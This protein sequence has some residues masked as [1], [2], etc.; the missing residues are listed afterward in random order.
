MDVVLL[1]KCV[2]SIHLYQEENDLPLCFCGVSKNQCFESS[3]SYWI[4]I[5]IHRLGI[6]G[7]SWALFQSLSR[8]VIPLLPEWSSELNLT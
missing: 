7:L 8:R 1:F 2:L 5:E 6:R 4:A 3:L